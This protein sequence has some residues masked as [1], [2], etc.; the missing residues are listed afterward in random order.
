MEN[1]FDGPSSTTAFNPA[2]EPLPSEAALPPV[3]EVD[4]PR[5]GPAL[6]RTAETIGGTL[7]KIVHTGRTIYTKLDMRHREDMSTIRNAAGELQNKAEAI[8]SGASEISSNV[9]DYIRT[10]DAKDVVHDIE[11][12][13]KRYPVQALTLAAIAGFFLERAL[14]K[15][16]C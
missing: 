5:Y 3:S 15:R 4:L 11:R 14:L 13:A 10:H 9:K 1:S 16:R 2:I 7:G 8:A 6:I 12:T